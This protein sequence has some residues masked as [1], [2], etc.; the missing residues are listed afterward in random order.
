MDLSEFE[1]IGKI[2]SKGPVAIS[3]IIESVNAYFQYNEDGFA[4]EVQAFGTTAGTADFREGASAFIE[5]RKPNFK[6][7]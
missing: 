7:K 2:A 6:G 4:R 5:K 3:K 1:L